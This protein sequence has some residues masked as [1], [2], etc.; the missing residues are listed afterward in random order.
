MSTD[1]PYIKTAGDTA[2][3]IPAE[4]SIHFASPA[5]AVVIPSQSEAL[6]PSV[7][8]TEGQEVGPLPKPSDSPV[9][10][11]GGPILKYAKHSTLNTTPYRPAH[12][13]CC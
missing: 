3:P 1:P 11:A 5:L 2:S 10:L 8:D 7:G 6:G 13:W 4:P 9:V 12:S